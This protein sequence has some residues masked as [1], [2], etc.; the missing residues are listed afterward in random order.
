[1]AF[2]FQTQLTDGSIVIEGY[3]N[4]N[5]FGFGTLFKM[6]ADVPDGN[7]AF[8]PG[9]WGDSR[10]PPLRTGRFFDSKPVEYRLPFSPY[11]IIALTPFARI[12]DGPAGSAILGD[13]HCPRVGKFT[14]PSGA[15]G[16]HLLTV[17]S[18]GPVNRQNGLQQPAV[19]GGIYLLK[20]GS[21][22]DEPGQLRL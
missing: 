3:Y 22:I 18:P 6:P 16:N 17:W 9:Y 11:R 5:N 13:E 12:D 14:H 7:P 10:N 19:D 1:N 2:H 21:A 15:P 8:G 20:S 4:L